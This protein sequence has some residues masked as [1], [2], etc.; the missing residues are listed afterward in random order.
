[1]KL[2]TIATFYAASLLILSGCVNSKLRPK[3][4]VVVDN[5]LPLIELTKTGTVSN[6]KTIALEWKSIE[7]PRVRGI[8]IYRTN[9]T[10]K[11]INSLTYY[12]IIRSRFST[13]YVD[14]NVEPN[15][16][17]SY[18]FVTY[19][20]NAQSLPTKMIMVST[21]PIMKSVSWIHSVQGMPRSAKI[22]WRPHSSQRV[23]SYL[24]QK[25]TLEDDVWDD[26]QTVDG[27]LN[28]EYIDYNLKDNFTYKY[29]IKCITYD[30]IVSRP[31]AEVTVI[32]KILPPEV[33]NITATTN[34][35]RGILI[36]W[37]AYINDDFSH[38]NVYRSRDIDGTYKIVKK[39]RENQY[40]DM[41]E[42]DGVRFFY[43]IGVVDK[44]GLESKH[45]A[46]S[47]Q[48]KSLEKPLTPALIG[49]KL[50][51]GRVEIRW[52][53]PDN[54][55]VSYVVAKKYYKSLF[56]EI[57]EEFEGI[58]GTEFIDKEIYVDASYSYVIYSID[59]YSIRSRPSIRVNIKTLKYDD[60]LKQGTPEKKGKVKE[61]KREKRIKAKRIKAKVKHV[62]KD[63]VIINN[64]F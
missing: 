26:L 7:D 17:Y 59:K 1:M 25:R 20:K 4:E 52:S 40:E 27:R 9:L 18:Y 5:T 64:D 15:S 55:A 8:Y 28:V 24:I 61:E 45:T 37:D 43:Q 19:S 23:K 31:S 11:E 54:R 33:Q 63:V 22:L 41:T 39:V 36:K 51:N 21:L 47:I 50:I 53:K 62:N 16:S 35:P 32:T 12:D 34:L 13:H 46:N 60:K 6:M 58:T 38:Y 57:N 3:K 49:A 42:E 10:S 2:W 48:G 44:D 14:K 29:R 30:G 56:N